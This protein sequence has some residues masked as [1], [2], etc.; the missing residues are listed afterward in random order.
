M[1]G[2]QGHSFAALQTL[3]RKAGFSLDLKRGPSMFCLAKDGETVLTTDSLKEIR[4]RL[5]VAR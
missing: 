3:A 2:D 1:P 5:T 4:D